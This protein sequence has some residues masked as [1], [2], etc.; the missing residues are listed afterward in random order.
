MDASDP[1]HLS[2]AALRTELTARL[3]AQDPAVAK[4]AAARVAERI[5]GLPE[6]ESAG[7]VLACLSFGTEL[8]TEDLVR[9]LLASGRQVYLPRTNPRRRS[10]HLHTYPCP[11][12][13]RSFGL[14]EPRRGTPE[15]PA[16]AVDATVD[17][18]L[19]LGLAFDRQCFRLGHGG[20]YFDRFLRG[21][22]FPAIGLAYHFQLLDRLPMESHDVPMAA[23]VTDEGVHRP[24]A[25]DRRDSTPC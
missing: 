13:T 16:G 5:L 11:L 19:V 9:R 6:L 7:C 20:G 23:V 12:M 2:K 22:P 21:R 10:L 4:A 25:G 24:Q 8:E 1:P 14:R 3:A 17:L 15:L 18:A